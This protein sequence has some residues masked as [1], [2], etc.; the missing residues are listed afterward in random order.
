MSIRR[1][2]LPPRREEEQRTHV[3][4]PLFGNLAFNLPFHSGFLLQRDSGEEDWSGN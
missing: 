1:D 4:P 2:R 3:L